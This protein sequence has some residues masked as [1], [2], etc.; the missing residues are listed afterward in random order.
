MPACPADAV[1]PDDEVPKG[2]EHYIELNKDLTKKWPVIK[3]KI[4][5]PEDAET[6]DG[7][8]DKLKYLEY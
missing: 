1:F 2:M 3:K 7:V 4:E 6:W 5:P 8:K